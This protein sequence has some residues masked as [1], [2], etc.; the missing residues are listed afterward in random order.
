M[1]TIPPGEAAARMPKEAKTLDTVG[2]GIHTPPI[3]TPV[4]I[5]FTVDLDRPIRNPYQ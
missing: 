5:P 4:P 3:A 2:S 1:K